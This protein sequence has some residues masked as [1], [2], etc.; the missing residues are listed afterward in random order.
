[1]DG[2]MDGV[3]GDRFV[4]WED[5]AGVIGCE[6]NDFALLRVGLGCM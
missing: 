5:E 3:D 6:A 2:S 1:M 4:G